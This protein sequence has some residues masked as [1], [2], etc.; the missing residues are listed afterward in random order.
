MLL[1]ESGIAD[2]PT[3]FPSLCHGSVANIHC[4]TGRC[5]DDPV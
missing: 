5:C 1:R 4:V 3:G 2:C